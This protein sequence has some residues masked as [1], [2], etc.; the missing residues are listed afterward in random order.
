MSEQTDKSTI[1]DLVIVGA[2]FCGSVIGIKGHDLGLNVKVLDAKPYY[3]N[4]FRAEKLEDDQCEALESLGLLDRIQPVSSPTIDEVHTFTGDRETVSRYRRHRGIHYADTVNSLREALFDRGILNIR[5]ASDIHDGPEA[6]E[7]ILNGRSSL[8]ARLVVVASGMAA[9]LRR[10]LEL[11]NSGT[12]R[13]SSTTFGFDIEPASGANFPLPA[14][15]FR[16]DT[17]VKGLQYITFFP[18]GD[19]TR[20]NLFTCWQPSDEHARK[21]KLDVSKE[22]RKLFPNIETHIGPFRISSEVESYSTRYYRHDVSHLTRTV[23]VGDAFQSVNPAN[24]VGLSKCL[25]DAQALLE[26][27]PRLVE[28]PSAG[29]DLKAYYG[30]PRKREVDC[31]ALKR[32]RWANELATSQSLR[33][34][35][36]KIRVAARGH[37]RNFLN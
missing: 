33:T 26:K 13:L 8:Q 27:L 36:K 16:P 34:Q 11:T 29:V 18:V 23:L 9:P 14:F 19:R 3:P 7:V 5:T 35:F 4:H 31:A 30:S 6:S 17:F 21:L 32:W 10:A 12:E 1:F 37:V 2:G 28:E 22:I 20:A 15:N 24:G 25:T